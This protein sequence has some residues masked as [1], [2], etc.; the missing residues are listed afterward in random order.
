MALKRFLLFAVATS[1]WPPHGGWDDFVDS[2]D[3]DAEAIA[4]GE[5]IIRARPHL[6]YHVVDIETGERV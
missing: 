4:Q 2:H 6:E 1:R 3:T 5:Q